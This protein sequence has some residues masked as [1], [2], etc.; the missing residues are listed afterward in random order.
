MTSCAILP[1]CTHG[2]ITVQVRNGSF[3]PVASWNCEPELYTSSRNLWCISVIK[4]S[5]HSGENTENC[6]G[7]LA[8]RG[9]KISVVSVVL[10]DKMLDFPLC[11]LNFHVLE[12]VEFVFL[13][14][15]LCLKWSPYLCLVGARWNFLREVIMGALDLW[16]GH[17]NRWFSSFCLNA[18]SRNFSQAAS[19]E[20]WYF[21][22]AI[23]VVCL[24]GDAWGE[25]QSVGWD[26]CWVSSLCTGYPFWSCWPEPTGRFELLLCSGCWEWFDACDGEDPTQHDE[27]A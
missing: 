3:G 11:G 12:F 17:Q 14:C 21:S 5:Y 26:I 22:K 4:D 13:K 18:A 19:D 20:G 24:V 6:V 2:Q 23:T 16:R 27:S 10:L 7:A 8:D 1:S 9:L 15:C 25:K